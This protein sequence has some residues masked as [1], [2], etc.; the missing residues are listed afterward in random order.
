MDTNDVTTGLTLAQLFVIATF[1]NSSPIDVISYSAIR[2][3][4]LLSGIL[5]HLVGNETHGEDEESRAQYDISLECLTCP[6]VPSVVAD[7]RDELSL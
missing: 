7:S 4:E 2:R 6:L 3:E 1:A 5:E